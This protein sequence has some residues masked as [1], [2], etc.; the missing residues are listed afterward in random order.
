MWYR[1]KRGT[2]AQVFPAVMYDFVP[3]SLYVRPGDY[4]HLQWTGSTFNPA[5]NDGEGTYGTDITNLVQ[6]ADLYH[7]VPLNFSDPRHFFGEKARLALAHLNQ[8]GCDTLAQL[9][10]RHGPDQEAINRDPRNCAKLNMA[11]TYQDQGL[12]QV[13]GSLKGMLPLDG[14]LLCACLPN[15]AIAGLYMFISTRNNNFS[16]R[17]QKLKITVLPDQE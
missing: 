13:G 8:T 5:F 9:L 12:H 11:S 3:N 2:L 6:V 15:W 14:C 1:G 17:S 4:I 10:A 16:K 7:N